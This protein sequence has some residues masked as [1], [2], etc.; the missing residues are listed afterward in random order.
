MQARYLAFIQVSKLCFS[1][2]IEYFTTCTPSI[3]ALKCPSLIILL[4]QAPEANYEEVER[5]SGKAHRVSFAKGDSEAF[6]HGSCSK[7]E[8]YDPVDEKTA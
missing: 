5:T 3:S 2:T 4:A 8:A 1:A 6:E 7:S